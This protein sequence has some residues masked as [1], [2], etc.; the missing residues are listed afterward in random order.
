MTFETLYKTDSNWESG[1]QPKNHL[2]E[3]GSEV[4]CGRRYPVAMG[5][6]LTLNNG[7]W[8]SDGVKLTAKEMKDSTCA[9]CLAMAESLARSLKNQP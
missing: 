1:K 3:L 9:Y 2:A 4:L 8:Y 7:T 5:G 6:R